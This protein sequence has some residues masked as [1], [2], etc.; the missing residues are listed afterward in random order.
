MRTIFLLVH[1]VVNR[2]GQSDYTRQIISQSS[3]L[4]GVQQHLQ[5]SK[6]APTPAGSGPNNSFPFMLDSCC[7]ATSQSACS[8]TIRL[9]DFWM[10]QKRKVTKNIAKMSYDFL[11]GFFPWICFAFGKFLSEKHTKTGKHNYKSFKFVEQWVL[12]PKGE[13]LFRQLFF[14]QQR[15]VFICVWRQEKLMQKH[16][17]WGNGLPTIRRCDWRP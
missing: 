9:V 11:F 7:S 12:L 4:Q 17:T 13:L 2:V 15:A 10:I 3:I 5:G 8:I 6:G 1:G 16:F 14:F